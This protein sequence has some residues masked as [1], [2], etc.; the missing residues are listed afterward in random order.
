MR[1]PAPCGQE[2]KPGLVLLGFS[3]LLVLEDHIPWPEKACGSRKCLTWGFH[4]LGGAVIGVCP[5]TS[6]P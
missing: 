4:L 5:S 1:V 3:I 2:T 6:R